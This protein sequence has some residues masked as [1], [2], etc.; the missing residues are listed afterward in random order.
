MRARENGRYM[1]RATN[2]GITALIDERGEIVARV[3]QFVATTLSGTVELFTGRTPWSRWGNWP[4]L[5]LCGLLLLANCYQI[6]GTLPTA[7]S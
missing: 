7:K 4:L 5:V 2:N 6:R 3:P 1:V